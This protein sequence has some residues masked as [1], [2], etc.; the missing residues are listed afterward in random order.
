MN[1]YQQRVNYCKFL[2]DVFARFFLIQL[3]KYEDS[4]EWEIRDE[5]SLVGIG[6]LV[7]TRDDISIPLKASGACYQEIDAQYWLTVSEAENGYIVSLYWHDV[8][9]DQYRLVR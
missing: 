8:L 3:S 4:A 2:A 6:E 7:T 9:E 1:E 5:Y